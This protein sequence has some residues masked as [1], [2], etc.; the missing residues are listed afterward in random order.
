MWH[1]CFGNENYKSS[2]YVLLATAPDND[3]FGVSRFALVLQLPHG[4]KQKAGQDLDDGGGRDLGFLFVCREQV[5]AT[6][7]FEMEMRV[8]AAVSLDCDS[9]GMQAE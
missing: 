2:R 1:N 5:C 9:G 7:S 4:G 6:C 8:C 3:D